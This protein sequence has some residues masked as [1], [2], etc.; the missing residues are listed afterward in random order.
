MRLWSSANSQHR[1]AVSVALEVSLRGPSHSDA[2][3]AN[4]VWL[5]ELQ[6]AKPLPAVDI[7]RTLLST[8]LSPG[9]YAAVERAMHRVMPVLVRL[10]RLSLLGFGSILFLP[11]RWTLPWL[12]FLGAVSVL[13]PLCVSLFLSLEVLALLRHSYEF[14]FVSVLSIVNWVG[15]GLVFGDARAAVCASY[16]LNSQTVVCI[17]ANYRTYPAMVKSIIMAG[18]SMLALVVCTCYGLIVDA[19]F[20]TQSIGGVTLSWRQVVVFTNS[21]LVI[22]MFKK[23]FAKFHRQ[24]A[25]VHSTAADAEGARHVVSCVIMR[26]R[27]RLVPA[28]SKPHLR[29]TN[30]ASPNGSCTQQLRLAFHGSIVVDARCTLLSVKQLER[31]LDPRVKVWLYVVAATGLASTA[32]AW[33]LVLSRVARFQLAAAVVAAVSSSTFVLITGALAQRDLLRLLVWNFDVWFSVL[34]A[35]ALALCLLDLLRWQASSSLAVLTWWLW[36]LW[37]LLLDAIT[38]CVTDRLRLHRLGLP[39]TL[40]ILGTASA[41][42]A[43]LL[44]DDGTTFAPRVVFSTKVPD[45]GSYEEHT[46]DLAVQRIVTIIGWNTRLLFELMSCGSTHQLLFIRRKIEYPSPFATFAEP[47]P[48]GQA[49]RSK[50][51]ERW[52]LRSAIAVVPMS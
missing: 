37:I 2:S 40:L 36:F 43:V 24:R 44:T 41:C 13:P 35:T 19:S 9:K 23:A 6:L 32:I 5:Y 31:S 47:L 45:L 20:P 38:P 49:V 51:S 27:M 18:P 48:G 17:D 7:S 46:D 3:I 10:N 26:A 52:R 16:W 50:R 42:A 14:W 30:S 8:I 11:T 4:A 33:T 22:F 12:P 1:S 34:Q 25:R 21:T 39:V 29:L 28:A 15:L